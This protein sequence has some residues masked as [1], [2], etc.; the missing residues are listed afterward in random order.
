M[1]RIASTLTPAAA[2]RLPS[3]GGLLLDPA[4]DLWADWGLLGVPDPDLI[5]T[6]TA[7]LPFREFILQAFPTFQFSRF[8]ELLIDLLQQVADGQLTRLIVCCPPRA[9]KLCAHDTGSIPLSSKQG[10]GL[11]ESPGF[12][13]LTVVAADP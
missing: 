6:T 9:G 11:P 13:V 8:S 10:S 1:G 3:E 5:T 12:A 2:P 4:T 7:A